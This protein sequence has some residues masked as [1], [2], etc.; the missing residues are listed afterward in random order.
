MYKH[1]WHV[2]IDNKALEGSKSNLL[3]NL[4]GPCRVCLTHDQMVFVHANNNGGSDFSKGS[5]VELSMARIRAYGHK[6]GA[7]FI[8]PGRMCGI[9]NGKLWMD[10]NDEVMAYQ[11]HH[12]IRNVILAPR[13]DEPHDY[14][15]RSYS[16]GSN[17]G[18]TRSLRTHHNNPPP[19]QIGWGKGVSVSNN[20]NRCD[21]LPIS[22]MQGTND[23]RFRTG[24]EGEHT[25]KKPPRFDTIRSRNCSTLRGRSRLAPSKRSSHVYQQ[26]YLGLSHGASLSGSCNGSSSASS[27]E[28]L[29]IGC[30]PSEFI[31]SLHVMNNNSVQTPTLSGDEYVSVAG[32]R[33]ESPL[34]D[35]ETTKAR[36]N[37]VD[38]C[39]FSNGVLEHNSR[40]CTKCFA[41]FPYITELAPPPPSENPPHIPNT[42]YDAH[43]Y[44][45]FS[46]HSRAQSADESYNWES[47]LSSSPHHPSCSP[48]AKQP[49]AMKK[50]NPSSTATSVYQNVL[51]S[52]PPTSATEKCSSRTGKYPHQ[53]TS[54]NS[55]KGSNW[56]F[57][58][59]AMIAGV[60]TDFRKKNNLTD[61]DASSTTA[62]S[63]NSDDTSLLKPDTSS[64][65]VPMRPFTPKQ[66]TPQD[67]CNRRRSIP[68]GSN[69]A[70]TSSSYRSLPFHEISPPTPFQELSNSGYSLCSECQSQL[71]CCK[72][73]SNED[74]S[75]VIPNDTEAYDNCLTLTNDNVCGKFLQ[76]SPNV[77]LTTAATISNISTKTSVTESLSK[78]HSTHSFHEENF[79]N[80][81]GVISINGSPS[82]LGFTGI[83][84]KGYLKMKSTNGQS[85][86]KNMAAT[87]AVPA[88]DNDTNRIPSA[89][90]QYPHHKKGATLCTAEFPLDRTKKSPRNS[91][92]K[93]MGSR[94]L[95]SFN[96]TKRSQSCRHANKSLNGK[97]G[98]LSNST[99][100]AVDFPKTPPLSPGGE[101]VH[102]DFKKAQEQKNSPYIAISDGEIE[103][104]QT[105]Y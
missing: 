3:A 54:T 64:Y 14:R 62:P 22:Q 33:Q 1:M 88:P 103:S 19:S 67:I 39:L 101:Y 48:T 98:D 49:I 6:E 32:S 61:I 31:P 55:Q 99:T 17:S 94:Q 13:Q 89:S 102:I 50:N 93:T 42:L 56:I 73:F 45:N 95:N 25:M 83:E 53:K 23:P 18:R 87:F 43:E 76:S 72:N 81:N 77:N 28:H 58:K 66:S 86:R 80:K 9:E 65:Y 12:T 84:E 69:N 92:L 63:T 100:H 104:T 36:A 57:T 105:S 35:C 8:E 21:S 75:T 15:G 97:M 46:A 4:H 59:V 30:S 79:Q 74:I 68:D 16:S 38:Y 40:F 96:L 34:L 10:L 82:G 52:V 85:T 71:Q 7:F 24:S 91:R 51:T 2:N 47:L 41:R 27:A 37:D 20:R 29:N 26:F 60:T 44:V 11:M 90:L 70:S 5:L 78:S